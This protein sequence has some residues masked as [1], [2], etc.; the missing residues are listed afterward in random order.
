MAWFRAERKIFHRDYSV[1]RHCL[2]RE[3]RKLKASR[4][5]PLRA[6]INLS[7]FVSGAGACL[8]SIC[9]EL[10]S[11][12]S[13]TMLSSCTRSFRLRKVFAVRSGRYFNFVNY[14]LFD[15]WLNSVTC[16]LLNKH[17]QLL[18]TSVLN[19]RELVWD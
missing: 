5:S 1:E 13:L 3:E 14:R 2:I 19:W 12:P 16:F 8:S 9:F 7:G 10:F 18:T 15:Y 6:S 4:A 11:G 17:C